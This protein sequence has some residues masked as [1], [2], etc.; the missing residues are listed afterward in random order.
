MPLAHQIFRMG[1]YGL[2]TPH[3][4]VAKSAS[5]SEWA[6]G[7]E[8]F[9]DFVGYYWLWLPVLVTIAAEQ[10]GTNLRATVAT[11]APNFARGSV[12]LL[13]PAFHDRL[14]R[15]DQH[16]ALAAERHLQQ[17]SGAAAQHRLQAAGVDAH[18]HR[19]ARGPHHHR[20]GVAESR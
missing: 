13:V 17:L 12:V 11:T 9:A 18:V 19:H 4:A 7:F 15:L 10:F 8:Y 2:L 6:R 1:Y 3:T 14:A 20:L 16:V 5:D